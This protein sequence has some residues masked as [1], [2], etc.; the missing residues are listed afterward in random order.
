MCRELWQFFKVFVLCSLFVVILFS[1]FLSFFSGVFQA[2]FLLLMRF[3]NSRGDFSLVLLGLCLGVSSGVLGLFLEVFTGF[4]Q[5]F[6]GLYRVSS[7]GF[8]K[9]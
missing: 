1:S 6:S 5:R 9:L 3:A 8:C 2:G 4:V 7:F